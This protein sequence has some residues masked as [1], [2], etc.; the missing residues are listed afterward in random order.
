[1]YPLQTRQWF[2]LCYIEKWRTT[3]YFSILHASP[4]NEL[5]E[6]KTS[7]S[8]RM[9]LL[10]PRFSDLGSC[11]VM[12]GRSSPVYSSVWRNVDKTP[13]FPNHFSLRSV[14]NKRSRVKPP[15]W[16]FD[17]QLLGFVKKW[18]VSLCGKARKWFCQ[19]W[20]VLSR[21]EAWSGSKRV[22]WA[23]NTDSWR[24][25]SRWKRI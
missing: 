10:L 12:L 13:R 23:G 6:L 14:S 11:H 19:I 16:I 1:M 18:R 22:K 24:N 15:S 7:H 3:I 21:A 17:S 20:G 4:Y 2:S 9:S 8:S 25:A 5:L